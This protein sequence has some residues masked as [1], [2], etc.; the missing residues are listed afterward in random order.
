MHMIIDN[1]YNKREAKCH[2]VTAQLS[3]SFI[4][5]DGYAMM[6]EIFWRQERLSMKKL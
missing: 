3:Y 2:H 4:F 1:V 5:Y 6:Y